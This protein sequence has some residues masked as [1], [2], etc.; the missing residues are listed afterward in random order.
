MLC[1]SAK[2]PALYT[3]TAYTSYLD[4]KLIYKR[5]DVCHYSTI[6]NNLMLFTVLWA[7][8]FLIFG[9]SLSSWISISFSSRIRPLV[10]PHTARIMSD[11]ANQ[12]LALI[13]T[14]GT[15]LAWNY[16][17]PHHAFDVFQGAFQQGLDLFISWM[18]NRKEN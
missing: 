1:F 17:T 18:L 4:W 8:Y 3:H 16:Q 6:L 15:L 11:F 14:M 2:Q 7:N 10:L 5:T 9:S 12:Y 13:K